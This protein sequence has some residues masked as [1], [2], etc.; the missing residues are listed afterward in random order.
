[1]QITTELATWTSAG[2]PFWWDQVQT[3]AEVYPLQAVIFDID[4]L[5]D[6]DGETR[7]GLVDLLLSLFATGIWVAVVGAG[8]RDWVQAR[9]RELIGDGMTETIVS[10]DDLT[11]PAGDAE[12]YRL[13]L[14]ELGIVAGETLVIAGSETGARIAS[15]IGLPAIFTGMAGYDGL[16]A[17]GCRELQ[18]QRVVAR[19]SCRAAG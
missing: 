11:G 4:A 13:A 6:A 1:M 15:A 17:N 14:W 2:R 12:L 16:L 9:V 18:A 10:A 5:S 7:S 19:F 3:D 8:P